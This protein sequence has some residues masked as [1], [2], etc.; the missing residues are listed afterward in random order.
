MRI[1]LIALLFFTTSAV[2]AYIPEVIVEKNLLDVY[3]ISDPELAQTFYGELVDFPHTYQI[4][5]TEPFYLFV[6]ISVPEMG[7]SSAIV[8]GIII[9]EPVG[10]GRVEEITRLTARDAVWEKDREWWTMDAYQKGPF[11]EKE[12]GPGTYRIEVHTPNNREK[13]IL[14]VGTREEMALGYFETVSRIA[15]VKSFFDKTPLRTVE[16]P[17]IWLPTLFSSVGIFL[18][19]RR[20]HRSISLGSGI[21]KGKIN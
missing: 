1:L 19:I 10:K 16:S 14:K 12:L 15:D 2:H 21:L 11:F 5:A 8:S 6:Q 4:I 20:K 7:T 13:Y 18:F 3:Q 17:L 9:K